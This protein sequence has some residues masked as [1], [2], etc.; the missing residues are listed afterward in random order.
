MRIHSKK[1]GQ[2][3]FDITSVVSDKCPSQV[4]EKHPLKS[5][6]ASLRERERE[7]EREIYLNLQICTKNLQNATT[8]F[9]SAT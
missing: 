3:F 1:L 8:V 2:N 6:F 4:L 7:R 9:F 5:L